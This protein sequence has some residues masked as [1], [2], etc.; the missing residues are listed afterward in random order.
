MNSRMVLVM[1]VAPILAPLAGGALLNAFGWRAIFVALV[2]LTAI[3]IGIVTIALPETAPPHVPMR[4]G[5]AIRALVADRGFVG[6]AMVV[7]LAIAG[8]FAYITGAPLVYITLHH[9]SPD[10]FGWWFGANALGFI[11][12]AQLNAKMV[13]ARR[14]SAILVGGMVLACAT[15]LGFAVVTL[16]HLGLVP[17]ALCFFLFLASLGFVLPNATAIALEDQ[18]ARAGNA[19]AWIGA[20]Q[21]GTAAAASAMVSAFADGTARPMAAVILGFALLAAATLAVTRAAHRRATARPGSGSGEAAPA[22]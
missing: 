4:R 1:G 15:A 19:A 20:M 9:V 22:A 17:T 11:G 10:H 8:L 16:G 13:I 12:A 18:G 3:A 5:E 14:P 7:S 21:F 6:H 2:A